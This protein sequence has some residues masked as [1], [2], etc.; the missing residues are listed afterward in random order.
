[1]LDTM[2]AY[3]D[4][5]DALHAA[6]EALVYLLDDQPQ[7]MRVAVESGC[8]ELVEAAKT[9]HASARSKHA[10]QLQETADE[11]LAQLRAHVLSEAAPP[12]YR[13]RARWEWRNGQDCEL[14]WALL[15]FVC[16]HYF[17]QSLAGLAH[18]TRSAVWC[19]PRAS[20]PRRAVREARAGISSR[21]SN[22]GLGRLSRKVRQ[23]TGYAADTLRRWVEVAAR[24]PSSR[25]R[26][27]TGDP[28]GMDGSCLNESLC[29]IE[30]AWRAKEK[31]WTSS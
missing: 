10:H 18:C 4:R 16:W 15:E 30:H 9:K 14:C 5:A 19:D 6:C 2:R 3:P 24:A 21:K 8:Q 1:M 22:G 13:A 28:A 27:D 7:N 17:S 11:L 31:L 20:L 26:I 29:F 12:P 25:R 23:H